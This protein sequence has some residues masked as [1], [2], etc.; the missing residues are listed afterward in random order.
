M[1][2]RRAIQDTRGLR[3]PS[4]KEVKLDDEFFQNAVKNLILVFVTPEVERRQRA[5]ELEKPLELVT[6]HTYSANT[7]V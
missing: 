2:L 4:M 6:V 3:Y 1:V 5:G 7:V